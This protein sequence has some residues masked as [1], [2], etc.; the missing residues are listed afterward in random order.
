MPKCQCAG[1]ACNCQIVAGD[2]VVISGT[3]NASAPYTIGVASQ[4][5]PVSVPTNGPVDVS[6][7]FTGA[8]ID[9]SLSANVTALSLPITAGNRIDVVIRHVVAGTTVTWPSGILWP[10]GAAPAQATGAN[11]TDWYSF[12]R[13]GTVWI[14]ALLSGNAF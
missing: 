13:I 11:R 8:V 12:R 4:Y 3:G 7:A 2:G 6:T 1:N 10:A 9:L 5:I 14:G